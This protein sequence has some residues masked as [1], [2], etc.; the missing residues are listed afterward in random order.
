MSEKLE[1]KAVELID[2]FAAKLDSLSTEYGPEVVDAALAVA[3][4]SATQ[5]AVKWSIALALCVISSWLFA[6]KALPLAKAKTFDDSSDEAA[7]FGAIIFAVVS[8]LTAL[9]TA[10]IS[11]VG[12]SV[13]P[14][15]GMF[16]PKLWIA[17]QVLGL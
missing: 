10:L 7:V 2:K 16:E 17:K 8:G 1:D 15:V 6:R 13:W 9:I 12:F 3:W 11:L 4:V 5:E 14:W